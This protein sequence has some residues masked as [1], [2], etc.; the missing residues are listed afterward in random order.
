MMGSKE[1]WGEW[2]VFAKVLEDNYSDIATKSASIWDWAIFG[3]DS[4]TD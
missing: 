1:F 3:L 2:G 4:N